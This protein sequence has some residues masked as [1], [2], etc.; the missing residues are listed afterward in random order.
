[1]PDSDSVQAGYRKHS[2]EKD[3]PYKKGDKFCVGAID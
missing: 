2:N 1:M 3:N